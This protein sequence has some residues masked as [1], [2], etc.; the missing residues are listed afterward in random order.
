MSKGKRIVVTIVVI[1]VIAALITGGIV[2][3]LWHQKNNLTAEVQSVS[4]LTW[5]YS[6]EEMTSYGRFLSGCVLNT[7]PD[8]F[9]NPGGGGAGSKSRG[10]ADV[11]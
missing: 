9:R 1:L 6:G 5:Y 3:Y 2:A 10:P 11:L 7:E 8:D 4:N